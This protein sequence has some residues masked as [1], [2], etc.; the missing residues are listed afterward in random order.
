MV[1][2]DPLGDMIAQ[3]KN[4]L[5][6]RAERV[7]LPH[8][9]LKE[10]LAKLLVSEGYLTAAKN[11]KI[12]GQPG[13]MLRLDLKYQDER[14]VIERIKRIS[15]PGQ[16]IY[17]GYKDIPRRFRGFFVLSTPRGL[18]TDREARKRHLGGEVICEVI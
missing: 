14:P 1:V 16:R 15:T 2:T 13:K 17:W 8:S 9:R 6:R 12:S 7:E 5:A 10:A 3:I 4:A 11:F 18:L